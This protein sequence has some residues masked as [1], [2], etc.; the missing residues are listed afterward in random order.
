LESI[1]RKPVVIVAFIVAWAAIV[2]TGMAMLWNFTSTPGQLGTPPADWP[3]DTRLARNMHGDTLVMVVHPHCSCSRA[4]LGELAE[5][6][7]HSDGRLRAYVLFELP[8]GLTTS[9]AET[10]L[11]STAHEI[12]GVTPLVDDGR[13][14]RR[15]GAY[16]S[17]QTMLYDG[18]G[19]LL[20]NGGITLGRSHF[21]DNDG[22]R[23]VIALLD[24]DGNRGRATHAVYGCGLF[25]SKPRAGSN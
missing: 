12:R 21:G 23:D 22:E 15:F 14:T 6:M 2:V 19:R 20:F 8:R 17:G 16:T 13:E 1:L 4:S 11:W 3:G 7:M 10:D 18:D 9:W 24:H 5:I 25:E